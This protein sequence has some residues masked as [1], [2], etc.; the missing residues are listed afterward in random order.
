MIVDALLVDRKGFTKRMVLRELRHTI[1]VPIRP[2]YETRF[3]TAN[4][5]ELPTIEAA[6]FRLY[7]SRMTYRNCYDAEY[8]EV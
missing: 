4:L 5:S 6:E 8:R 7:Q 1:R 2:R 3:E